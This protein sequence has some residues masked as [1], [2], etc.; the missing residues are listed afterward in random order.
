MKFPRGVSANRL[1][2]A[3]T[4]LGYLTI[5]QQGSHIRLRHPGPTAHS[6]TVPNHDPLKTGTL[7]SIVAGVA[8]ALQVKV[9][10]ILS[11]L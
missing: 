3:L 2:R 6:V 5:R 7:H 11:L 9:D 1:I 8:N 10:S 4:T